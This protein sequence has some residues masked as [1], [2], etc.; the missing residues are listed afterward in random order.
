MKQFLR[1]FIMVGTLLASGIGLGGVANA[2]DLT[3]PSTGYACFY[4]DNDF[5]HDKG[6]SQLNDFDVCYDAAGNHTELCSASDAS[7]ISSIRNR[8]NCTLHLFKGRNYTGAVI[9]IPPQTE[10]ARIGYTYGSTW[11]DAI[12]SFSFC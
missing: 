4:I 6:Y 8:T 2:F 7:L 9:H 11:N 1:V 5:N 3:C 12:L 10:V